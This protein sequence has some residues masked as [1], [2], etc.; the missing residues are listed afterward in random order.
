MKQKEQMDNLRLSLI[1]VIREAV[2]KEN[3]CIGTFYKNRGNHHV[4][5]PTEEEYDS[6][7]V[8]VIGNPT[9]HS[10][11]GYEAATIYDLY[12][13]M[14]RLMCTL[15]GEAG[16]DWDESIEKVQT[17][18]LIFITE[19]LEENGFIAEQP[20]NPYRCE[21]CGSVNLLKMAWVQPNQDNS[22]VHYCGDNADSG[23][24]WCEDCEEHVRILLEDKLIKGIDNWWNRLGI[25][26]KEKVSNLWLFDYE[27]TQE[28]NEEFLEDA[29]KVWNELTADEKIE[30]WKTNKEEQP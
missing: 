27:A 21:E 4:T 8:V 20:D 28:G 12:I 17:E 3:G 26:S 10:Y 30:K 2:E 22:F 5:V 1:Q 29:D 6:S 19:W 15:N 23:E 9:Y 11:G 18:G 13:E 25:Y 24:H 14:D 7:P 16:E